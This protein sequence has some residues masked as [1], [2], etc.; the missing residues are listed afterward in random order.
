MS[1]GARRP[2][3][4]QM[5]TTPRPPQ[6]DVPITVSGLAKYVPLFVSACVALTVSAFGW[7]VAWTSFQS[8]V[9]GVELRVDR[10]ER[11]AE[12][13]LYVDRLARIEALVG[14]LV[15]LD[16]RADRELCKRALGVG[17]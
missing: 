10:L 6:P 17:R 13:P 7:G 5:D 8:R 1:R 15:C 11:S 12:S 14:E 9:D 2:Y 3:S 4:R 16:S